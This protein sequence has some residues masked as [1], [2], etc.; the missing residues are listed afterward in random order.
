MS[1]LYGLGEVDAQF[2][3]YIA[4][5]P[6]FQ[7]FSNLTTVQALGRGEIH[8]IGQ[9]CGNGWRKVFNVYSKLLFAL[10]DTQLTHVSQ[11]QSWQMYRDQVLLQVGSNTALLFSDPILDASPTTK[12]KQDIH[13]VMGKTYANSLQLA[14]SLHWLDKEFAIDQQN[15]LV[16]CPYFDYRQLSNIKIMRLVE[17]IKCLKA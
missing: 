17:L 13:V 16:V 9:A 6:N 2:K 11:C 1:K 10:C 3:V 12:T 14:S 15:K 5:Q 7:Q 4:N 8:A